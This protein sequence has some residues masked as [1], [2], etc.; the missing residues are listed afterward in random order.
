MRSQMADLGCTTTP[1][2]GQGSITAVP[3]TGGIATTKAL[4]ESMGSGALET[5]F[6]L[7]LV[8]S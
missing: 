3:V 8:V 1:V 4:K 7:L 2:A 5:T 6:S